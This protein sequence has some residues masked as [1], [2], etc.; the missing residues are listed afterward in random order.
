MSRKMKTETIQR[1]GVLVDPYRRLTS[2]QIRAIHEASLD[3]LWE[4]G[5][6][7]NNPR[8]IELLAANGAAIDR[9]NGETVAKL[10]AKLVAQAVESSPRAVVL[11]ARNPDNRLILDAREPRVRFGTGSETNIWLS[12][13]WEN[14]TI[15]G[16][17]EHRGTL[18][19]LCKSARLCDHLESVDF[20]I[21]NVN[22]QDENIDDDNKDVNVFFGS[23]SNITKHVMAGI[24]NVEKLADVVRMAELI[25]GGA[26]AFRANPIISFIT[27]V[28][29]SPLQLVD[30]TADK[31]VAIA[32]R[33]IPLVISSSPQ[34][35]ATGPI[36]EG[37]MVAMINAEILAGVLLAQLVRPAAPVLYGAVPA[38]ARMD[39]LHNMYGAPETNQYNIDCVQ[40]ARFYDIP[41]YS[42]AGV[43]DAAIPG[44]QT[45][46]EKMLSHLS[47]TMSGPQYLHYAFG[48]L[49]KTNIFCPAQAVLDDAHIAA[50]KH[51]CRKPEITKTSLNKGVA[52]L[53]QVMDSSH[54]LFARYA[55]KGMRSGAISRPYP[56]E[57]AALEDTTL[58]QADSV[59]RELMEKTVE[60]IPD[61][62]VERIFAALPGIV[63]QLK[64]ALRE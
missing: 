39:T 51:F 63:S 33:G 49:D 15:P 28:I 29:K 42:T 54:K 62:V 24:N 41:C 19:R 3:I 8:I 58:F 48:L 53:K 26:D 34:G 10:P 2:R 20:F 22:I 40:M 46:M 56:F 44:I 61:D 30:D 38:R 31:L 27:C 6:T 11:G 9:K 64:P 57:A 1:Q 17:R 60:P 18:E 21:R 50:V 25:T 32:E 23:L 45:T 5:I 35:G 14:N 16:F 43:S 55:R 4:V 13:E 52:Q 7:C 36:D 47:V 59:A 12:L 37:D